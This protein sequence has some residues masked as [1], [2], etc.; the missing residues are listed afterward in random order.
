MGVGGGVRK[1]SG[2][3]LKLQTREDTA[4]RLVC[5][6]EVHDNS[7]SPPISI[8]TYLSSQYVMFVCILY[9]RW[10]VCNKLVLVCKL[11]VG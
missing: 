11:G 9:E 3:V 6:P 1:Y 8:W 10:L 7:N 4:A 2:S 5:R